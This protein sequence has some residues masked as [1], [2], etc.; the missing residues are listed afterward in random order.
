M[1][2][3]KKTI[4][5]RFRKEIK[6]TAI[7]TLLACAAVVNATDYTSAIVLNGTTQ[8]FQDGDSITAPTGVALHLLNGATATTV[9][10][11]TDTLT[12]NSLAS[13][14]I[15]VEDSTVNLGTVDITAA[16]RG[17]DIAG[18]STV[19]IGN[20]SIIRAIAQ[21]A[22][23]VRVN[24]SFHAGDD[25]TLIS[26]NTTNV[27][28]LVM[29]GTVVIGNRA[30]ISSVNA[31]TA[32]SSLTIGDYF[33]L[34]A[35]D[36]RV[37][38]SIASIGNEAIF[39][40]GIRATAGSQITFTENARITATNYAVYA[41]ASK[42]DLGVG[43]NVTSNEEYALFATGIGG[44]I[45]A[46]RGT[47]TGKVAGIVLAPSGKITLT[48]SV[49]TG[50][51]GAALQ[52][53]VLG[54]PATELN[55]I[56]GSITSTTDSLFT[57]NDIAHR[58]G[59]IVINITDGAVLTGGNGEILNSTRENATS[60]VEM[61][62]FDSEI[63]GTIN[64]D[65]GLTV[66]IADSTWTSTGSSSMDNLILDKTIIEFNMTSASDSIT[67]GNLT[68]EGQS[69]VFVGF[70]NDF[71][72]EVLATGLM[73]N[74]DASIVTSFLGGDG[75]VKYIFATS[76]DE[77]STWDIFNYGDGRFG[78]SAINIV[79]EPSTYALIFGALALA[80]ATYRRRK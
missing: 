50:E 14:G 32:G 62:V 71:L 34:S 65:G 80:F 33:T 57:F 44:E 49:V 16:T 13:Y 72:E 26:D 37:T 73:D 19:S 64:S 74:L 15:N 53:A 20:N 41:N 36:F 79:P 76:N 59:G 2:I 75:N 77:G 61:N 67:V 69:A 18:N 25:L 78:I 31:N 9:D 54:S 58:D 68:L 6:L 63:N 12:I 51:I 47:F 5:N 17:I 27:P 10:P 1:K 55:I 70:T 39:N 8:T 45:V 7:A 52:N 40:A 29:G 46:D 11:S 48:D 56:G 35:G 66:K 38:G 21:N 30:T 42:I 4:N 28:L 43:A 22:V 3:M 60:F 23:V 24:S